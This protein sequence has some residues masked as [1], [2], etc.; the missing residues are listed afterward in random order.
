MLGSPKFD[1]ARYDFNEV[2]NYDF[3][4]IK[5]IYESESFKW[6]DNL[7]INAPICVSGSATPFNEYLIQWDFVERI[8]DSIKL[9]G[10]IFVIGLIAMQGLVPL[11]IT[12]LAPRLLLACW[13]LLAFRTIRFPG[14]AWLAPALAIQMLA[15]LLF[16]FSGVHAVAEGQLAID[17]ALIGAG[18]VALSAR[19]YVLF[20][21]A[22]LRTIRADIEMERH[23][24]RIL[25]AAAVA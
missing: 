8:S 7:L 14:R 17:A 3:G 1:L 2:G 24:H 22:R 12:E 11:P 10:T 6:F 25:S 16:T 21:A 20:K 5:K 19:W 4:I 23:R 9:G 13:A 15:M 18:W